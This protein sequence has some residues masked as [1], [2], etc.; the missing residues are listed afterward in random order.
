[1][2]DFPKKSKRRFSKVLLVINV[3]L[4]WCA[5][6]FAIAHGEADIVVKAGFG[7]IGVLYAAYTGVGHMDM[8]KALDT[9]RKMA[10]G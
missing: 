7:L 9:A 1:M 3:S 2:T 10:G 8:R 5:V 6:F 4:A